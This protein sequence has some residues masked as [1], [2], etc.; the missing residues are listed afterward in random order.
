MAPPDD[1]LMTHSAISLGTRAWAEEAADT[2][3]P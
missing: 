1:S 2:Y 3:H